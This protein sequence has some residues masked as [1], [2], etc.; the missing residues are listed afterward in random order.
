[1]K[2]NLPLPVTPENLWFMAKVGV[3][4]FRISHSANPRPSSA[5]YLSGDTFRSLA[6]HYFE[7]DSLQTFLPRNVKDNDCVFVS[8]PLAE[9]FLT[10]IHPLITAR[11]TLLLHNGDTAC[12]KH[13]TSLI[14]EKIERVYSQNVVTKHSKVTPIPIGLENITYY[15]HGVPQVFEQLQAQQSV[16]EKRMKIVYGFSLHTNPTQR[17]PALEYI[18]AHDQ[19]VAIPGRLN[20]TKYLHFLSQHA[21][22]LSPPGNGEDCIRTWEALY[23]GVIPIVKRSVGMEYFV[24]LG[25]PIWMVDGWSE[26]DSYTEEKLHKRYVQLWQKADLSALY[27]PFWSH[28]IKNKS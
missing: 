19:G 12:D 5:P 20:A 4:R 8:L 28:K 18:Q 16:V 11:Y 9:E 13:L 6:Q 27:F 24:S 2:L 17:V 25:L 7:P 15:N 14:D 26:L 1:M 10:K 3:Q 22:V 23:L 21:F